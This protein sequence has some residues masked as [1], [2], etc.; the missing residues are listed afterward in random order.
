M[1]RIPL[2][3]TLPDFPWDTLV[4][5]KQKAAEHPEGIV[6]LSVGSPVDEVAPGIQLALAESAA[7]PGYPQTV[8][9][10]RLRRAIVDSVV[11]RYGAMGLSE[12]AV[13][14][15]V[16]TK[17]AIAWLP[18]ALGLGERDVVVIPE[19][20]YPTY[21]VAARL[22]GCPTVRTDSTVALGPQTPGLFFLN[23][24]SN[25]TGRVLGVEHL[26]KVVQWARE[27]NV[28]VASD[29]CYLGLGWDDA[30]RPLSILHPEVCDGDHR[31]L[32]AIHSLSKTSNLAGYRAGFLAGD[33]SLIGE[34]TLVRKHAGLIVPHPIQAAMT[35]AL[36]EDAQ[37]QMQKMRYASRRAVLLRALSQ[38]GF[39]IE[40]SQAGL[41]LWA[42]RG[43]DCWDTVDWLAERGIVV[44]PGSFY[45]PAGQRHVRISLTATDERIEAA[46][47]RLGA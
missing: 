20:A 43:E 23:S 24:P 41:Y 42:T 6:N 30:H 26:R 29:E 1:T 14:P 37:E 7:Y 45:G 2:G 40:H 39:T 33:E 5:A 17:E 15:V 12:S 21:E 19:L 27:R 13:L 46:A 25:P 4:P 9:T 31:N 28:I 3:T 44:A 16:G 38:A 36:E 18:T 34:L 11:R 22:A 32:L 35:A 47:A 8:G 10:P